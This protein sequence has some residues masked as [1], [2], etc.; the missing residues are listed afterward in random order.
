[1]T[2][3][4]TSDLHFFHNR[5]IE[6]CPDTRKY[7]DIQHMH[8]SMVAA[9]NLSVQ[10]GDLVYILGDCSFTNGKI[11]SEFFSN[12]NGRKIL[13]A[14]NHDTKLLKCPEFIE[15]F[16]SIH[17]ILEVKHADTFIVMCH[18]PMVSWN[19]SHFGSIHF[20]GHT[21]GHYKSEFRSMDVGVDATGN[22]VSNLDDM[23]NQAS[24]KPF[25]SNHA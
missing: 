10:P 4:I 15:C 7:N 6:L 19:K 8:E 5:I 1:M 14:G 21:H 23:I 20:Y 2:T 18:F 24:V 11:T 3:W 9:W 13:V 17:T 12:L 25:H 22:I 16:E